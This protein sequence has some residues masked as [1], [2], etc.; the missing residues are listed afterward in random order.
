MFKDVAASDVE[1]GIDDS[2][3]ASLFGGMLT[4]T[5]LCSNFLADELIMNLDSISN[6][7]GDVKLLNLDSDEGDRHSSLITDLADD[8]QEITAST[9]SDG[10]TINESIIMHQDNNFNENDIDQHIISNN[11]EKHNRYNKFDAIRINHSTVNDPFICYADESNDTNSSKHL[12]SPSFTTI[13]VSFTYL[14]FSKT[15]DVI[16]ISNVLLNI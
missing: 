15:L 5:P 7:D 16:I 3:V 1:I 13:S 4:S 6:T 10:Y 8:V 2:T 11:D 9:F 12:L 14:N